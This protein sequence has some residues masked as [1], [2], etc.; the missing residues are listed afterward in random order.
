M[1]PGGGG[2]RGGPNSAV[3][4]VDQPPVQPRL[5]HSGHLDRARRK[6][7]EVLLRRRRERAAELQVRFLV[8]SCRYPSV[9]DVMRD[10]YGITGRRWDATTLLSVSKRSQ[11][12]RHRIDRRGPGWPVSQPRVPR[13]S[14][15]VRRR[16]REA[17][18]GRAASAGTQ[19]PTWKPN[20]GDWTHVA[21]NADGSRQVATRLNVAARIA[22]GLLIAVFVTL[23][24]ARGR[25]VG[26]PTEGG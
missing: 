4:P 14:P 12:C 10:R 13:P 7:S 6:A 11:E 3:R 22:A 26:I 8:D 16:S 5:H 23:G 19:T 21:M 25:L 1:A 24:G 2:R 15:S 9:F 20:S 17:G 18:P